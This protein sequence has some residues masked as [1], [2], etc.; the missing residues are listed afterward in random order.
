MHFWQQTRA[1]QTLPRPN[2]S[3]TV[4]SSLCG[5]ASGDDVGYGLVLEKGDLVFQTQ[6]AALDSCQLQ[7]VAE[8]F[9]RERRQP[10]VKDA[11]LGTQ[12]GQAGKRYVVVHTPTP[13]AGETAE[14]E[15]LRDQRNVRGETKWRFYGFLMWSLPTKGMTRMEKAQAETLASQHA[16]IQ[17]QIDAEERRRHPDDALIHR[18]K[19]EKLRLKDEM[20]TLGTVH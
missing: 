8:R 15:L 7:L 11:V 18:L 3:A 19:K 2:C 17:S 12:L 14:R 5:T 20:L 6:F 4:T 13:S 10:L 9:G 16:K 1:V